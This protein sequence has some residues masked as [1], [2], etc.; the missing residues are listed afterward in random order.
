MEEGPSAWRLS[1]HSLC[2]ACHV[3]K[4]CSCS[5]LDVHSF[6]LLKM[7]I[8]PQACPSISD[9]K[10]M[11]PKSFHCQH[12]VACLELHNLHCLLQIGVIVRPWKTNASQG[13]R[14]CTLSSLASSKSC[15]IWTRFVCY[16]LLETL[17]LT[18]VYF[19]GGT[20]MPFDFSCRLATGKNPT[21]FHNTQHTEDAQ[22]I[23][24]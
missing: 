3:R 16:L 11:M 18:L 5:R 7:L 24:I 4:H 14:S 20:Y 21:S 13:T 22:F 19:L 8:G 1:L 15:A 6:F 9:P 2:W 12:S 17:N 10:E 23:F